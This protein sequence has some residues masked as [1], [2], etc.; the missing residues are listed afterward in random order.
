VVVGAAAA[1]AD[2]ARQVGQRVSLAGQLAHLSNVLFFKQSDLFFIAMH[3]PL[4][5][6]IISF[7]IQY[8]RVNLGHRSPRVMF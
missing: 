2:A 6:F 1:A 5:I 4:Y 3:L 8:L 7:F